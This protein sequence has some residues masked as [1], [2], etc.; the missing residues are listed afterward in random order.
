MNKDRFWTNIVPVCLAD[1]K[2]GDKLA[3]LLRSKGANKTFS[4]HLKLLDEPEFNLLLAKVVI[5]A[6]GKGI[7][8]AE[9]TERIELL[10]GLRTA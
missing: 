1:I 5:K 3:E 4:Q 2:N 8:G 9:L 7:V 6:S 10:K